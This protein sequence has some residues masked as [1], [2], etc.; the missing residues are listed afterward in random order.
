[1]DLIVLAKEPVPGRVKTR[2]MPPCDP[3]EAAAIATAALVDTL[4]AACSSGADRVLVA[5]DGEPGPWC[6]PGVVVVDQGQGPLADRLATA[7]SATGGPAL[8]VGMDTPQVGAVDLDR[9]MARLVDGSGQA[10]LGPAED[11]GWWALG[12]RRPHRA[13]F[14]GI[15]MSRPDTGQRQL[16][17][18][19]RLGLRPALLAV[20]RD[21]DTWADA[22]AVAAQAPGSAFAAAVRSTLVAAS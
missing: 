18:L 5:L 22:L 9:A 13:A 20:E 16:A 3:A 4:S 14:R 11:G 21:V 12:L 2:L 19:R 8:Q 15:P 1:V 10:V 7:W 17:R 6:P